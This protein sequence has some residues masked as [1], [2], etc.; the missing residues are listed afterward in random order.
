MIN[1]QL[2]SVSKEL[3]VYRSTQRI[4]KAFNPLTDCFP[5]EIDRFFNDAIEAARKEKEDDL[6]LFCRAIESYFDYPEPN[7]WVMKAE[8]PLDMYS[9]IAS[10]LKQQDRKKLLEK[11]LSLIPKVRMDA[12][13]PPLVEP[14]SQIIGSQVVL[15]AL[16]E[17]KH[18][19]IYA[20]PSLPFLALI[21]GEYGKT[22]LPINPAF[23]LN[24]TGQQYETPYDGSN[25]VM[26]ENLYLDEEERLLAENE[27]ELL[28]LELFPAVARTFLARKKTT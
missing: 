7:D 24:L 19:P 2:L 11:A 25:Y 20:N 17:E 5:S 26:Q 23:R 12:G 21:K 6:L 28:L 3:S 16:N 4:P 22:P 18:Q 1:E 10:R 27:Q 15:C 14:F 8:L 13:L 9:E